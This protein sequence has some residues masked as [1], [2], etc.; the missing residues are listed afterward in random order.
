MPTGET[1]PELPAEAACAQPRV[2]LFDFDGVI[3][4]G[5]SFETFLRESLARSRWRLL[6]ALPVLPFV[7][8][9]LPTRAGK[10]FLGRVFLRVVTFGWGEAGYRRRTAAFG[11][12]YAR[13][14]GVFLREGVVALRRHVAAGDRV[15]IVTGCEQ[16]VLE[17]IL[18][19]VRLSGVELLASRVRGGWFGMRSQ[20]HNFGPAKVRGLMAAGVGKPWNVAYS[21]SLADLPML[22]GA[23][24]AVLVNPTAKQVKR[25]TRSLRDRLEVVH[26]F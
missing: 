26:W 5:D 16:S 22:Q 19:E 15:V 3:V 13:R 17:A 12:A 2:V 10:K 21:D 8:L 23:E 9:L 14:P 1:A 18:D 20:F 7:P 11:Q 25:A 24:R 4:R 6:L